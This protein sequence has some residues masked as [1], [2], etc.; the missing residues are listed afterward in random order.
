MYTPSQVGSFLKHAT[1]SN[2]PRR[3]ER[4]QRCAGLLCSMHH[5]TSL[6]GHLRTVIFARIYCKGPSLVSSSDVS[7]VY[8]RRW[9]LC[10]VWCVLRMQYHDGGRTSLPSGA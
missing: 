5:G 1:Y 9:S 6:S 7:M 3:E 2:Q 8:T 10:R 4:G